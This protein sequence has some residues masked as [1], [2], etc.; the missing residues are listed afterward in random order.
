MSD[1][2]TGSS[3]LKD[4]FTLLSSEVQDS[5]SVIAGNDAGLFQVTGDEYVVQSVKEPK[6]EMEVASENTDI[7][8]I[9]GKELVVK[10]EA[11]EIQIQEYAKSYKMASGQAESSGDNNIT[12]APFREEERTF[13]KG[14]IF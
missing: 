14:I 4:N 7:L 1:K 5:V 10:S 11:H 13:L 9:D 8:G 3:C 6:Q 2:Q 12:S